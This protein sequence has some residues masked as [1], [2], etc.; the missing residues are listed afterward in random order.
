MTRLVLT[1]DSSAAGAL[2]QASL[3]DLVLAI[4]R[5]FV[6]GAPPSGARA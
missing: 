4:N 2:E 5:R 1:T 6:W 3:G